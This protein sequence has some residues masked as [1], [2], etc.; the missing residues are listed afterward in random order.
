M[1]ICERNTV[2][3]HGVQF[4]VEAYH[5]VCPAHVK[6]APVLYLLDLTRSYM[7]NYILINSM[8]IHIVALLVYNQVSL[9]YTEHMSME[10]KW[11]LASL[12]GHTLL[13]TRWIVWKKWMLVEMQQ[14]ACLLHCTALYFLHQV[15]ANCWSSL[16]LQ[17]SLM[18][19]NQSN[20]QHS[21]CT[22][23]LPCLQEHQRR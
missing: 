20:Y 10:P 7:Y 1:N 3:I 17:L 2:I 21:R 6:F 14:I 15:F 12:L 19:Q 8:F 18:I 13:Y 16:G 9:S 5:F 23:F 22:Y 11:V 4:I